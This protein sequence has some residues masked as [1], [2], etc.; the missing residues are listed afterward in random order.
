MTCKNRPIP[1][2]F[3]LCF[4]AVLAFGAGPVARDEIA[5]LY[6]QVLAGY[7]TFMD[8]TRLVR[9]G[10]DY[11]DTFVSE[12]DR[13]ELS[14]LAHK[15]QKELTDLL[16]GQKAA[17]VR[18]EEYQGEDWDRLYGQS[19][20]WRKLKNHVQASE[21]MLDEVQFY[22]ALGETKN[23][24]QRKALYRQRLKVLNQARGVNPLWD[25]EAEI[26]AVKI[27]D[28][29]NPQT[30]WALKKDLESSVV[31]SHPELSL[32]VAYLV[33]K[34]GDASYLEKVVNRNPGLGWAAGKAAFAR[35]Q[36]A[37]VS[38]QWQS[39][40]KMRGYE[41]ELACLVLADQEDLVSY[42]PL[43]DGLLGYEKFKLSLIYMLAGEASRPE[44]LV[45]AMEYY[46]K[47]AAA[48]DK[49]P[50]DL[51]YIAP[52]D[53]AKEAA[54]TALEMYFTKQV[55]STAIPEKAYAYYAKTA[56]SVDPQI[57]YDY[58]RLLKESGQKGRAL[59]KLEDL[60][61]RGGA[62]A[63]AARIELIAEG[64]KVAQ[65]GS[66]P[67]HAGMSML[68]ALVE[69]PVG[70]TGP[71]RRMRQHARVLFCQFLLQENSKQNAEEVLYVL[72]REKSDQADPQKAL[73]AARAHYLLEEYHPAVRVLLSVVQ[74][75]EPS[76]DLDWCGQAAQVL[77][78]ITDRL[79]LCVES[80]VE[81]ETFLADTTQAL[82]RLASQSP[83]NAPQL[84]TAWAE[85]ALFGGGDSLTTRSKAQAI[86]DLTAGRGQEE[87]IRWIRAMGRLEFAK[88]RYGYAAKYWT[89][90]SRN[91]KIGSEK[92]NFFWWRAKY[93]QILC[94]SQ[95]DGVSRDEVLR[96]I[97]V[98]EKGFS[99]IPEMWKYKIR[100]IAW[101]PS[102]SSP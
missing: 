30:V 91:T 3:S 47:A 35:L 64:L 101:A 90:V 8:S 2:L 88:K 80:A 44:S 23:L 42:R 85:A 11:D 68:R 19:G 60:S 5:S 100:E 57:E 6:S 71:E 56:K 87:S 25:I 13:L 66:A 49:Q 76:V 9:L 69:E 31:S 77:L 92:G 29:M 39:I 98:L 34:A 46:L 38:G 81:T 27:Q 1:F 7:E 83:Q 74:G 72:S 14:D 15:V 26:L 36:N 53:I 82:D 65:P 18:I 37:S 10:F 48:M 63:V 89:Q 75:D 21:L 70:G 61:R 4:F 12:N 86:L 41:A 54:R 55:S 62:Y 22:K 24:S 96:A 58:I 28:P 52:E 16:G 67:W 78:A 99:D 33:A 20:L 73:L 102:S 43:L 94:F 17:L 40:A 45:R 93:Y 79:E 50:D 59:K 95:M 97:E 32:R 51:L 84:K